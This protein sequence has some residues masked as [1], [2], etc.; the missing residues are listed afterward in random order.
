MPVSGA[1]HVPTGTR[2]ERARTRLPRNGCVKGGLA[3][4]ADSE[5]R[6]LLPNNGMRIVALVLFGVASCGSAIDRDA[7]TL[8]DRVASLR[9]RMHLQLAAADGIER[10]IAVGDLDGARDE[11]RRIASQPA[12]DVLPEWRPYFDD[13]R[14]AASQIADSSE[15]TSAAKTMARLGRS[16]ARCHEASDARIDFPRSLPPTEASGLR[17]QM[18]GHQWAADQM[19]QGLIGPSE[20]RWQ[21]GAR[22]LA[23]APLT[24]TAESG[25]LGIADDAARA[26]LLATRAL[27][28]GDGDGRTTLYGD[29]LA[30]CAHCHAAIRDRSLRPRSALQQ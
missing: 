1:S 8:A 17:P 16:C 4:P 28:V 27:T 26:K 11:A 15:L 3:R 29:L 2:I 14:A 6:V 25:E 24:M 9:E 20:E 12:L 19:W 22:K 23:G 30:T 13:I 7:V 5:A 21:S 10:A 18:A